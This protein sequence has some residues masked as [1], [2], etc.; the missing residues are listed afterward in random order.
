VFSAA[1]STAKTGGASPEV[2]AWTSR[3]GGVWALLGAA[4]PFA[5]AVR[6][7]GGTS[8]ICWRSAAPRAR[9]GGRR[10]YVQFA[11]NAPQK[12]AIDAQVQPPYS[13]T[14]TRVDP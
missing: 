12:V 11:R 7:I 2:E 14:T 3:P 10:Y 1:Y 13:R 8:A 6:Q 9:S 4:V 5:E